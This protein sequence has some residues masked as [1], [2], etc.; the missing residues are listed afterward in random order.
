MKPM[1][2]PARISQ[3]ELTFH[4]I[5]TNRAAANS[6]MAGTSTR[7]LMPSLKLTA[8][9]RAREAALT[10][11]SAAPSQGDLRMR[12]MS[13]FKKNTNKNEGRKMPP[14]AAKAP[15]KPPSK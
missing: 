9:I 11:S 12:G 4:L 10:P 8:A 15:V 7:E 6:R 13:G 5:I 1:A 3:K 2:P 14:V